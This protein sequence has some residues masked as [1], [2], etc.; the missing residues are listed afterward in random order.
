MKPV[1]GVGEFTQAHVLIY[2]TLRFAF[3]HP[4]DDPNG[5]LE[6]LDRAGQGR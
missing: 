5:R 1:S 3:S 2:Y 4:Y 6:R